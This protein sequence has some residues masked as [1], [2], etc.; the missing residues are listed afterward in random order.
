MSLAGSVKMAP[1][2]DIA[3]V[4]S[5]PTA[6]TPRQGSTSQ[7]E[8][9]LGE[10]CG[11]NRTADGDSATQRSIQRGQVRGHVGALLVPLLQKR[12]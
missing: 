1:S 9:L 5:L 11:A 7:S 6:H 2:R 12:P 8:E 4:V 3:R 10:E